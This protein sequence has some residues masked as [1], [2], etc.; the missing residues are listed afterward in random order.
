MP[1]AS[2]K[3]RIKILHAYLKSTRA[4]LYKIYTP[5][6]RKNLEGAP[7]D[8]VAHL[9]AK[10]FDNVSRRVGTLEAAF[11]DL[12]A[13]FQTM[14]DT[15]PIRQVLYKALGEGSGSESREG[16]NTLELVELLVRKY[17]RSEHASRQWQAHVTEQ[18]DQLEKIK[19]ELLSVYPKAD[20]RR[21][22]PLQAAD[23]VAESV[24]MLREMLE[25]ARQAV[26]PDASLEL[27]SALDTI[28]DLNRVNSIVRARVKRVLPE[29]AQ[30]NGYL[31]ALVEALVSAYE[32]RGRLFREQREA[33]QASQQVLGGELRKLRVEPDVLDRAHH[34][35]GAAGDEELSNQDLINSLIFLVENEETRRDD[36][37]GTADPDGSDGSADPDPTAVPA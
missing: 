26:Q 18:A 23:G 33:F 30:Y 24:R 2:K 17:E 27:K 20:K 4:E 22:T 3:K 10:K 1:K 7:I 31:P 6:G 8:V 28:K 5:E 36:P 34:L 16:M 37:A 29:V 9:V 25:E 12:D 15:E 19:T 14:E 11:T 32:I 21:L 13:A 35:V